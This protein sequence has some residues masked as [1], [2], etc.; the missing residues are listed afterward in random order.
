MPW[1]K[2]MDVPE[3]TEHL[4]DK[5][6]T[7]SDEQS[8]MHSIRM[9]LRCLPESPMLAY[10]FG[11]MGLMNELPIERFWGNARVERIWDG[12]SEI[13]RYIIARELRRP[14]GV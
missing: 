10:K 7:Q 5:F 9:P 2:L 6:A 14:L 11:G 13:Q 1:A 4:I 12:M 8:G 3:L